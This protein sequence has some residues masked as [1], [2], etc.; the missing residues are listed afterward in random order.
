MNA[1][2]TLAIG[3]FANS[4]L[5]IS[6]P[7]FS[8][9]SRKIG[10]DYIVIKDEKFANLGLNMPSI[11]KFQLYEILEQYNRIIYLDADIILSPHLNNLFD[12]VPY[13]MI[14]AVYDNRFNI[15]QFSEDDEHENAHLQD[16]IDI[17]NILGNINWIDG[18]INTG[19]LVCSDIHRDIFKNPYLQIGLSRQYYEQTLL[20]YNIYKLQYPVFPL[21]RKY[22]GMI[23]NGFT[24]E[25]VNYVSP[26]YP[27]QNKKDALIMHF[28][29]DG[30]ER[31]S[32]G[33]NLRE[34]MRIHVET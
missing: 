32:R 21:D 2:V 8:E 28:A 31:T 33:L 24:C 14:G 9:Y 5:D 17:Q 1:I 13:D 23:I 18:Y 4:L 16:M 7:L 25:D 27:G 34:L 26:C 3:S 29:G 20:N 22:N 11:E 12:V 15:P 30:R 10:A 6:G 19:V